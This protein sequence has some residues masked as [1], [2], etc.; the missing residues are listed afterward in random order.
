MIFSMGKEEDTMNCY[1]FKIFM[2]AAGTFFF[3]LLS[4]S[5]VFAYQPPAYYT[6][7]NEQYNT[8]TRSYV[9]PHLEW[10]I[11][12]SRGAIRALILAPRWGMRETVELMERMDIDAE[13]FA[14]ASV[15]TLGLDDE[16]GDEA[17][18]GFGYHARVRK[19]EQ[20]IE[21]K[22]DVVVFAGISPGLLP[23][24]IMGRIYDK[25]RDDGLGVI[26]M[27]ETDASEH[28][29]ILTHF[30]PVTSSRILEP[31]PVE[32][33]PALNS[34]GR[35]NLILAAGYGKGRVAQIK[36]G[37]GSHG[38][39]TANVSD[40]VYFEH[41]LALVINT[42]L[43]AADREPSTYIERVVWPK[44]FESQQPGTLRF[45][46]DKNLTQGFSP[47]I[48]ILRPGEYSLPDAL[49][50]EKASVPES[51]GEYTYT[52]PV[53]PEGK[54]VFTVT[55]ESPAAKASFY[56]GAF[57]VTSPVGIDSLTTDREGYVRGETV[58][59]RIFLRG[60]PP[61]GA[62]VQL[63][64]TD[65]FGR[66]MVTKDL[67]IVRGLSAID[68]TFPLA[69]VIHNMLKVNAELLVDGRVISSKKREIFTPS[70]GQDDFS[71]VMW[72]YNAEDRVSELLNER[73][74]RDFQVDAVDLW[75]APPVLRQLMRGN[76]RPLPYVTR[77]AYLGGNP[78]DKNPIRQPSL[79]DPAY[80]ADMRQKLQDYARMAKDFSPFGYTFGD[81]NFVSDYSRSTRGLD[82]DFHPSSLDSFRK[83]LKE[84][85]GSIETLNGVW[86][87]S[88]SSW[89]EATPVVQVEALRNGQYAR[90]ID[91]R[92]HMDRVF[93]ETHRFAGDA[94]REIDPGARTG[95]DG[96][97]AMNSFHGYD[98]YQLL[99]VNG[100]QNIYDSRDQ[101]ELLRS[102]APRDALTGIW[103]G[104]YPAHQTEDQQRHYP[105]LMLFHGFSSCWYWLPYF[106]TDTPNT[107]VGVAPDLTPTYHLTQSLE[108]IREIKSGVGKLIMNSQ[109]LHDG[110]AV[111]YSMASLH[112][113]SLD[114]TMAF[115]PDSQSNFV[116]LMEDAGFQ[117]NFVA[118]PQ[119]ENGALDS[120]E[121]K[122]LVLP[123]SQVI[124][125][126]ERDAIR[127]FV[128]KGGYL[129]ADVRPGWF[130]SHG[131]PAK[132]GTLDDIFGIARTDGGRSKQMDVAISG[133]MGND[134]LHV[135]LPL[136]CLDASVTS[137]E[138][139]PL[140][141]V[142]GIPAV[143][144][145]RF[146]KGGAVL[147]NFD[148]SDYVG[149]HTIPVVFPIPPEGAL[150]DRGRVD[151]MRSLLR[152]SFHLAGVE[153]GVF[154]ET[155]TG[156]IKATESMLFSSGKNRYLGIL[157]SHHTEDTAPH[158]TTIR[159]PAKYHV[160][161][162]RTG[163][164]FGETD[165][166]P[167]VIVPARALLYSLLTYRVNA[168]E[169]KTPLT[170]VRGTHLPVFLTVKTTGDTPGLHVV[171]IVFR[172][173]KGSEKPCYTMNLNA[174]EGKVRVEIPIALNDMTGS[175]TMVAKD[176]ATGK[177]SEASFIVK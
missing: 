50:L 136:R 43:W 35:E 45:G 32:D 23:W 24:R 18:D 4:F 3:F 27:P 151:G 25:V 157:R 19:L 52:F 9:T 44:T 37:G 101:R 70:R 74:A 56:S 108:E 130:D 102:F 173:P 95:F 39:F 47:R 117:Y 29:A 174:P 59:G 166:I 87:T 13:V 28:N 154:I 30:D 31:V 62:R 41:T 79:T 133:N 168:L 146:G 36:F 64:V 118:T 138:A 7:A 170:V 123:C 34:I 46:V 17:W 89:E 51:G 86:K 15:K 125:E 139:Q 81:E 153:P 156:E 91:H 167:A 1:P 99:Q 53:L 5:A 149:M 175:W 165:Q 142:E 63:S 14:V 84:K 135:T 164:Y 11:P 137:R 116:T 21:Q 6:S 48:T 26:I 145:N 144:V 66:S 106:D 76:M 2:A 94:V 12:Y 90:W 169:I 8:V 96:T 160:Y 112:A 126:K 54:Y 105:W 88:F 10:A 73:M 114:N 98:F 109:R 93:A 162:A 20:L 111:H 103:L 77:I 124:S 60:T 82:V 69:D 158:D 61:N 115:V 172:D 127:R 72:G 113:S 177:T 92:L 122:I 40:P 148:I 100:V 128:E 57:T 161:N 121:Y 159:L 129:V 38:C 155:G 131:N 120:G 42:I 141:K 16:G 97:S 107:M 119:I 176:A 68:F 134:T 71:F 171:H 58:R 85:Y 65:G 163:D 55:L 22:W 83:F 80:R 104:S 75:I 49:V 152:S 33:I 140:V 132:K 150:R 143:L 147:F 78:R 110:I 67:G